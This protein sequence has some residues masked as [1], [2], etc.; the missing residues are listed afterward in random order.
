MCASLV[1]IAFYVWLDLHSSIMKVFILV[2]LF[3][4]LY[5]NYIVFFA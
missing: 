2:L 3:K 4:L 5:R 1:H